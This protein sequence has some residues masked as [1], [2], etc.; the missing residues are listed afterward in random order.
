[1]TISWPSDTE[2]I[3]DSIRDAIGRNITILISVSGVACTVCSL[4]PVSNLSTNPFCPV[5]NGD[6]WINTTS[7]YIVKAH[8]TIGK[9]DLP[10]RVAGGYLEKGEAV[11]QIKYTPDT[12]YAVK[13]AMHY[14]VDG[15]VY[16][17]NDISYRGVPDINRMVITLKEQ[18]G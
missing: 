3:I 2:D 11:V 7:G 17:E 18:E 13:H 15:K 10:W 5:C 6:Y 14:I 8:V 4:N 1:M 9:I 12:L 16:L